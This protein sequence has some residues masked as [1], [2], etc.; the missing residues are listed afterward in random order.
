M[1]AATK[2]QVRPSLHHVNIKTSRLDEMIKW[3]GLVVGTPSTDFDMKLVPGQQMMVQTIE[4]I[5]GRARSFR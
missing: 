4:F 2:D 3:Y 5:L 1:P